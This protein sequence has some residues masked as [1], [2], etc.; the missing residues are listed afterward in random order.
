M[1]RTQIILDT[2]MDTDCDDA[3]ALAVLHNLEKQGRAEILGIVCSVPILSCTRFV[4]TVNRW[5]GR[6]DIAIGLADESLWKPNPRY[7]SYLKHRSRLA[8]KGMSYNE[9][10]ADEESRHLSAEDAIGVYRRLLAHAPNKSVTICAVGT[11][12]ALAAVLRSPPDSQSDLSGWKLID[13]K[14]DRLVTMAKGSYPAGKDPFNW[15][16]D[17]EA[18][19]EVM[20]DWP[21]PVVVQPLGDEALTGPRLLAASDP[22]NPVRR[23]YEIWLGG[24][25]AESRPS[26]DQLAAIYSVLGGG[27]LFE[28]TSGLE[29]RLDPSGG[30]H[31]WLPA[32]GKGNRGYLSAKAPAETLA[33]AVEDLMIG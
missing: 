6:T 2:D 10:V 5:H 29:I 1:K 23:A 14:V 27:E 19:A 30:A 25:G 13:E 3:G 26:W 21:T 4:N 17:F 28:E 11:L 8:A 22:D 15:H 7:A 31:E 9:Q 32:D 20:H 18:A 24:F 12:T 16:M 33:K